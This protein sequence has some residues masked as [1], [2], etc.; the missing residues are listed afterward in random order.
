M[1]SYKKFFWLPVIALII[2]AGCGKDDN[3]NSNLFDSFDWKGMLQNIGENIILKDLQAFSTGTSGLLEKVSA[4]KAAPSAT[5]LSAAQDAW[6]NVSEK[7]AACAPYNFGPMED[8]LLQA[9][10]DKWPVDRDKIETAI[11]SGTTI[12]NDYINT[13]GASEK[14]M[15]ALEYLLFNFNEGNATVL[16]QLS[17]GTDAAKRMDYLVALAQNLQQQANT[18]YT[19]WDPAGGNYLGQFVAADGNDV[20]SSIGKL[21]NAFAFYTDVIK[22]MKVG[23]AIGK[24]GDDNPHPDMVELYESGTSLATI[25]GNLKSMERVFRG[26]D[27]QGFDDLLNHLNAQRNGSKLSEVVM[28]SWQQLYIRTDAIGSPLQN[29]VTGEKARVEELWTALKEHL[30]YIKVDMVN[31]LGVALTFTD[32]DGD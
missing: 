3:K 32:D 29:A 19:A 11:S 6:K 18:L 10:I 26:G 9:K 16:A 4:L 14:G 15:K 5:T 24:M 28:A 8:Q 20:S 21:V 17:T 25:K 1:N 27:G 13:R 12:N 31:N 2:L 7:W 23:D 30:V 22:N